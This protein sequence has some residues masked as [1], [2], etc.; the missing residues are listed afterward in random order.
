MTILEKAGV[1]MARLEDLSI[2]SVVNGL[3]SGEPI[4]VVSTKWYGSSSM[5]VFYKTNRGTTGSQILY[6]DDEASLTVDRKSVV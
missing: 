2:G 6:R 4:T 3:L 5:E 1:N